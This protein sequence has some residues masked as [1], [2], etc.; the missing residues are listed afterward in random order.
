[1]RVKTD[2]KFIM[3]TVRPRNRGWRTRSRF[4][5]RTTATCYEPILIGCFPTWIHRARSTYDMCCRLT[6]AHSD[7]RVGHSVGVYLGKPHTAW[8]KPPAAC[9]SVAEVA[10]LTFCRTLTLEAKTPDTPFIRQARW[11]GWFSRSYRP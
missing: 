7:F 8:R 6:T 11:N 2:V 1:M 5:W 4:F 3:A 10:L 9:L